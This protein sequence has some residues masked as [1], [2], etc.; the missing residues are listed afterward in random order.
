MSIL[1]RLFGVNTT[2]LKVKEAIGF[3][4][5]NVGLIEGNGVTYGLSYQD[6]GNGSSRVKLLISSLYQ[7][8]TYECDTGVN[9]ANEFKG[10]L[11][12]TLIE[13]SAEVDK[14][15][16]IFPTEEINQEGKKYIKSLIFNTYKIQHSTN[17]PSVEHSGKVKLQKNIN[18][19]NDASKGN[20]YFQPKEVKVGNVV[21]VAH[22]LKDQALVSWYLQSDTNGKFKALSGVNG[23][24]ERKLFKFN[25]PGQLV[26]DEN[27][28]LYT[29]IKTT[30]NQEVRTN[31]FKF[32]M[33]K[34]VEDLKSG[35]KDECLLSKKGCQLNIA[36][37]TIYNPGKINF[38]QYVRRTEGD[39]LVAFLAK[40]QSSNTQEL[41]LARLAKRGPKSNFTVCECEDPIEQ[42]Y[43]KDNGQGGFIVT[44]VSGESIITFNR[45]SSEK[46]SEATIVPISSIKALSDFVN[47]INGQLMPSIISSSTVAP[48]T[49]TEMV[50]TSKKTM[51][52]AITSTT[53]T[54]T[55]KTTKLTTEASTIIVP[56]S[57]MSKSSTESTTQASTVTVES[58]TVAST[59]TAPTSTTSRPSTESTIQTST[60]T[61]GPTTVAKTTTTPQAIT[62]ATTSTSAPIVNSEAETSTVKSIAAT[63]ESTFTASSTTMSK[64]LTELTTKMSTSSEPTTVAETIATSQAT[65]ITTMP[66]NAPTTNSEKNIQTLSIMP[67][68]RTKATTPL[69]TTTLLP[70]TTPSP[71]PAQL[72]IESNRAGMIGGSLL[73]AI[74]SIAGI[75]GFIAYKYVKGRNAA[76]VLELTNFNDRRRSSS[77]G[78]SD[79][80]IFIANNR[81]RHISMRTMDQ[82]ETV[83]N[84]ISVE[85]S[86]R[87]RSSS[88]SS[89]GGTGS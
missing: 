73:G 49:V 6:N 54:D 67:S 5:K 57:T 64:P 46:S 4:P 82:S 53:E 32:D 35:K 43:V 36:P 14:V 62:V 52:A 45:E 60:V 75:I 30:K 68:T 41:P 63:V 58:K 89:S 18:N 81:M 72:A 70:Q 25:N 28:I 80:E 7:S 17:A 21:V 10:Q 66:T 79:E 29:Q 12:P 83:L 76:L 8:K 1:S 84:S 27:T 55:V 48:I 85:S 33:A 15:G 31:I 19:H 71:Q 37:S 47:I 59:T 9:V 42:L 51:T 24:I 40:K 26:L 50:V 69:F 13:N 77:S 39:D 86:N 38:L 61:V 34:V 56:T 16:V 88:S 11:S 74:I 44:A 3:N 87:S 23:I 78:N 65:M 22:N 2:I 20:S